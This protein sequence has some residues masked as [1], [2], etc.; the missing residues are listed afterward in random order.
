[1]ST[2]WYNSCR[3]FQSIILNFPNPSPCSVFHHSWIPSQS[4]KLLHLSQHTLPWVSREAQ[5]FSLFSADI[6][7]GLV[8]HSR[9]QIKCMLK[10]L[11]RGCS[12]TRLSVNTKGLIL[13]LPKSDTLPEH[14]AIWHTRV[15]QRTPRLQALSISGRIL[16]KPADFPAFNVFTDVKAS[17]D[18]YYSLPNA[19]S[20]CFLLTLCQLFASYHKNYTTKLIY[21]LLWC[22]KGILINMSGQFMA[23]VIYSSSWGITT[24]DFKMCSE[25]VTISTV[26]VA[27]Q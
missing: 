27:E 22:L 16:S 13:Q 1:M 26:Y 6:H 14:Q 15:S 20:E 3:T 9:K 25:Q 11:F 21:R 23:S 24:S 7:P 8:T 10:I 2:E 19:H 18:G 4:S 12:S 17:A 5:Y